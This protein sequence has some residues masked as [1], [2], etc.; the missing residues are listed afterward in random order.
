[1]VNKA[2]YRELTAK[3]EKTAMKPYSKIIELKSFLKKA[4]KIKIKNEAEAEKLEAQLNQLLIKSAPAMTVFD[5]KVLDDAEKLLGR[6]KKA[7]Q[8]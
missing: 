6:I 5:K 4:D 3:A 7:K 8:E 1:M 2:K